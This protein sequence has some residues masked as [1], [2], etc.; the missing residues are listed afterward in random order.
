MARRGRVGDRVRASMVWLQVF[1]VASGAGEPAAPSR[2]F[3]FRRIQPKGRG[4]RHRGRS[5]ARCE[6]SALAIWTG[7]GWPWTVRIGGVDAWCGQ[8]PTTVEYEKRRLHD[9]VVTSFQHRETPD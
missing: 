9:A 5:S 3:G 4:A 7:C 1:A 8:S 2:G 6:A